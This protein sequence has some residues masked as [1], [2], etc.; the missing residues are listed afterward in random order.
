MVVA[1][2][3]SRIIDEVRLRLYF[4]SEWQVARVNLRGEGL[5]TLP[6]DVPFQQIDKRTIELTSPGIIAPNNPA[7]MTIDG[8]G[9]ASNL[10]ALK[11]WGSVR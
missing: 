7:E 11:R 6:A 5:P 1:I 3:P 10:V 2:N 8:N 4:D 9:A